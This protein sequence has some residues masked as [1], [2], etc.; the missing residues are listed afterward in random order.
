VNFKN[1]LRKMKNL[2]F[3][4]LVALSIISAGLVIGQK[5][6][7]KFGDVEK[8]DLE[9]TVYD[10]DSTAQAVILCDYGYWSLSDYQFRRIVRFKILTADGLDYANKM[11]PGSESTSVRGRT[12]N[13]ENG[14]I[15][16]T[17]LKN[18]SVFKE[19]VTEDYYRLRVAMPDVKIGSVFD[20]EFT[21][22]WIPNEWKFQREIPVKYSELIIP[23]S[24]YI[25]FRKN[26]FGYVGLDY[27]GDER[28]VA[29]DMPAFKEEPYTNSIENYITKFEFDI[30]SIHFPGLYKE[31]T[32]DWNAVAR[33]LEEDSYFG[34]VLNSAL[35]LNS[36]ASEI[37]EKNLTE[38]EKIKAACKAVYSNIKWNEVSSLS[39]TYNSLNIALKDGIGNSAD[40]NLILVNL[41]RK[42]DL[43]AY[44][45]VLSTRNNGV[46]P[47]FNASITKLNY[48]IAYVKIGETEYLLDATD[49]LAPV[50]ILPKRCLNGQGRVMNKEVSI[51]VTLKTDKKDKNTEMYE[52]ELKEDFS[53]TGTCST[54]RND[55]G[56]YNFRKNY[57]S[58]NGKEEYIEDME[59]EN[60][61]LSVLSCEIENLDS[62]YNPIR[63]KYEVEI[64]NHVYEIDN[65]IFINPLLHN[66]LKENP[67]KPDERK[68]PVDYAYCTDNSYVIKI[69]IPEG[70]EVAQ[71]PTP[72]KLE[73]P[74]KGGR[75]IYQVANLNNVINISYKF[76][77]NKE[78]FSSIEYPYLKEFYNQIIKKQ[79]EPIVLNKI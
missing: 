52:L 29:K 57:K 8:S 65:Q 2:K 56:A 55:Y 44:P 41:L 30:L 23:Q 24:Q 78:T 45:V 68:Y 14:E 17:K 9:M 70:Y 39:P 77:I 19:R 51:P 48:I 33:R 50:G 64:R 54:S 60:P 43:N 20:I 61:G 12:F 69:K 46:L 67:F 4:L 1:P 74:E 37:K 49:E 75:I 28:W 73:L 25:D 71:L 63:E 11:F 26:Y 72:V 34:G 6:P 35:Y 27:S 5:A 10:L 21:S 47:P 31:F 76:N 40:I 18:E 62:I 58:F 15:I 66:Q 22:P 3:L 59:E 7:I 36:M 79:A 32:T 42:L 38:I 53:L 13:L 16:E